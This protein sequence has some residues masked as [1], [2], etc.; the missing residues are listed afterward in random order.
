MNIIIKNNDEVLDNKILYTENTKDNTLLVDPDPTVDPDP[1]EPDEPENSI[2]LLSNETNQEFIKEIRFSV[3]NE[4]YNNYSIEPQDMISI[5]K[6]VE[7]P[8]FY[9]K[10]TITR[11][12][13]NFLVTVYEKDFLSISVDYN[14]YP[15][16]ANDSNVVKVYFNTKNYSDSE[17]IFFLEL[18]NKD[19]YH[20]ESH[21]PGLIGL[22]LVRAKCTG[23]ELSVENASDGEWLITVTDKQSSTR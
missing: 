4:K 11:T 15:D 10:Y 18:N 1:P 8:D 17:G 12:G 2:S 7:T 5:K 20:F 3:V 22:S 23:Y 14:N 21:G 6:S 13:N 9:N 16:F 19:N